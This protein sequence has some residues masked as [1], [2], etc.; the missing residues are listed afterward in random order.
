MRR[1][2]LD[3]FQPETPDGLEMER[4][5]Q[6]GRHRGNVRAR[7][8]ECRHYFVLFGVHNAGNCDLEKWRRRIKG[9][10]VGPHQSAVQTVGIRARRGASG[11]THST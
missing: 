10:I 6:L 4:I 11:S 5:G 3:I 8:Q 7:I 2:G 9:A 1:S